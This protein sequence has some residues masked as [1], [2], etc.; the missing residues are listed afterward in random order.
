M[1]LA[2]LRRT[3]RAGLV[4]ALLLTTACGGADEEGGLSSEEA[5]RLNEAG[6]LLD[7]PDARFEEREVDVAS[8]DEGGAEAADAEE[9][10][11]VED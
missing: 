1:K 6:A 9:D 11:P 2:A 10:G 4:A 8:P 3:S 7:E 5:E